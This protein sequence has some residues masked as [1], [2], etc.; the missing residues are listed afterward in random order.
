M[1]ITS[2][3]EHIGA[4]VTGIDLR[5]P[6]DARARKQLNDA[7]T[8]HTVLI[9]KRQHFT[10][11][12]YQHAAEVFGDLMP[13][14]NPRYAMK[15]VPLVRVVSNRNLDSQG[16]PANNRNDRRWHTDHVNLACPPKCTMLYGV[17]MPDRGGATGVCNMRAAYAALPDSW[18]ERIRDM[19]R[20][21]RGFCARAW[22]ASTSGLW[23]TGT[24]RTSATCS[25]W[26]TAR[27]CTRRPPIST[28][29]RKE[30]STAPWPK[31]TGRTEPDPPLRQRSRLHSRAAT[32]PVRTRQPQ[33]IPSRIA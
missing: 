29:A 24:S 8:D 7:L 31:A 6:L 12:Q 5:E 18:K 10:P 22:S 19:K 15:D 4:E 28:T 21:V 26:T 3:K 16:N 13:D 20:M 17:R 30:R 33:T 27:P 32:L 14:Q 23:S 9:I 11:L 2:I 1:N 25:S